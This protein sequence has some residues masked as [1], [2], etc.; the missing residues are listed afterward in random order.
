M[1]LES[2]R[3]I[4]APPNVVWEKLN[5]T[6]TLEQCIAGCESLRPDGEGKFAVTLKTRIGPVAATFRGRLTLSDVVPG[7][8]YTLNFDGQ[9]GAAG[10]GRGSAEVV[11]EPVD[12]DTQLSYR[13][14]AQIGG[15]LAQL[16]QRLI[17]SAA[18]AMV[19]DFFARFEQCVAPSAPLAAVRE[20]SRRWLW[21]GLGIAALIALVLIF[22]A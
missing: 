15:R 22:A 16:G 8:A 1:Q 2:S 21:V 13:A 19:D 7:K 14:K 11:L 20:P 6:A 5:D 17:D 9:G 12:A 10:F 18:R 3:R 4:N